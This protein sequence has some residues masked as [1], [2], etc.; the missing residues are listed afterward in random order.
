M[1]DIIALVWCNVIMSY[2]FCDSP[3]FV[4]CVEPFFGRFFIC[5]RNFVKN[6]EKQ[7]TI[8]IAIFSSS[9]FLT[10]TFCQSQYILTLKN[11]K[12]IHTNQRKHSSLE[13]YDFFET[14]LRSCKMDL[15]QFCNRIIVLKNT[16][17]ERMRYVF[18]VV[19]ISEVTCS[20]GL[21]LTFQPLT[22]KPM[23]R[24]HK[25]FIYLF[26]KPI[27]MSFIFK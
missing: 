3:F 1:L 21:S 22:L 5:Q 16:V 12:N 8:S 24:K 10:T 20:E 23:C 17:S 9:F 27:S 26:N 11:L 14:F 15:I 18:L 25:I 2:A 7:F 13:H 4:S 19:H 6:I